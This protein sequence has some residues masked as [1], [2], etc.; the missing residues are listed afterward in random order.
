MNITATEYSI[1]IEDETTGRT[2]RVGDLNRLWPSVSFDSRN[3]FG[4]PVTGFPGQAHPTVL[5]AV[6][7]GIEWVRGGQPNSLDAHNRC[8][9]A[10]KLRQAA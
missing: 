6:A 4:R 7:A 3:R 2:A 8:A 10:Y 9:A 1:W 5:D